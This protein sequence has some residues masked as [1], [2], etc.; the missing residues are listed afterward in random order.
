MEK[1]EVR[2]AELERRCVELEERAKRVES[3]LKEIEAEK[4]ETNAK[5]ED[6]TEELIRKLRY[7]ILHLKRALREADIKT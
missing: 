6:V 4:K 2:V 1:D 7:Q 3:K 5:T